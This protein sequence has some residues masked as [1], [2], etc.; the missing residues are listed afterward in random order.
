MLASRIEAFSRLLGILKP[1][2]LA[3]QDFYILTGK[4]LRNT[5]RKPHY[6]D[7][8]FLQM[9]TI[10]VGSLPIVILTGFFSGAVMA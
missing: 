5:V 6:L 9:D 10:G 7:D 3:I 4:A 1:P 8:I 2:I